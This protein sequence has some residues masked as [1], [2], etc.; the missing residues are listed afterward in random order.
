MKPFFHMALIFALI[1]TDESATDGELEVFHI[2]KE[3]V[4]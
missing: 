2:R 4:Y 1:Q 3:D